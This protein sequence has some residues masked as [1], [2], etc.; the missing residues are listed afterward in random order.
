MSWIAVITGDI[1]NSTE[2]LNSG[3]REKLLNVLHKTV[4]D[5]NENKEFGKIKIEIYR[6]DSFQI[7]TM[8]PGTILYLAIFIRAALITNTEGRILWD[9]RLGLGVGEAEFITDTITESD[10][11]AFRLSGQAFDSL[12]KNSRMMIETPNEDF[13]EELKVSTAF[14]DDIICNWTIAQASV[15]YPFILRKKKQVELAEML[16]KTPQAVNKLLITGKVHLIAAYQ[17]RFAQKLLSIRSKMIN[18]SNI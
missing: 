9:A 17:L 11:E 4:E 8:N 2:I 18:P 14:A 1:V 13:N 7:T 10:G 16:G 3:H 6:G 12:G 5:I 15:I